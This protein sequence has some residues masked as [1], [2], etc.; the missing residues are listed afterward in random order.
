MLS[1]ANGCIGLRG[2]LLQ[3]VI[4]FLLLTSAWWL[5]SGHTEVLIVIFGVLSIGLVMWIAARMDRFADDAVGRRLG[6]GVQFYGKR[7]S[8]FYGDGDTQR[9]ANPVH[10]LHL[11]C[12]IRF[13]LTRFALLLNVHRT[14]QR[15]QRTLQGRTAEVTVCA[16]LPAERHGPLSS[17]Q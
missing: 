4:S 16:M 3:R 15:T 13:A 2:E 7:K 12:K 1:C 14:R 8:T 11:S 9:K 6:N 5:L 17:A 10:L